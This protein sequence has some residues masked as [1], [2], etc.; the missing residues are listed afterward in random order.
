MSRSRRYYAG[1]WLLVLVV[2]TLLLLT[3]GHWLWNISKVG[4]PRWLP[5]G[6]ILH[7]AAY[8]SLGAG[9]GWLPVAPARRAGLLLALVL[10]G[11]LTEVGQCFVPYRDGSVRDVLLDA[12]SIGVGW[13]VA[14][15]WW[16]AH[17]LQ[18]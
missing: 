7:V 15:R 8:S 6:K 4:P 16:P 11:G 10:H 5:V 18:D 3:P 9:I 17:P 12:A 13:L 1:L 2:W 14:R